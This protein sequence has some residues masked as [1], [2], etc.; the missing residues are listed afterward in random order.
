[1][2][3]YSTI[4]SKSQLFAGKMNAIESMMLRQISQTQNNSKCCT[5]YLMYGSNRKKKVSHKN[6]RQSIKIKER[7]ERARGDPVT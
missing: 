4:T 1:M 6:K 7:I 2:A 5:F 3:L